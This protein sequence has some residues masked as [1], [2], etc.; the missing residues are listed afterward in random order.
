MLLLLIAPLLLS[1]CLILIRSDS[2]SA[3]VGA[4]SSVYAEP[5]TLDFAQKELQG[6]CDKY[7]EN[8]GKV[9][10][11]DERKQF[12]IHRIKTDVMIAEML[13]KK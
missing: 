6:V 4:M 7:L 5:E 10:K 12:E 8:A 1:V 3:A 9:L 2:L 13:A 11:D